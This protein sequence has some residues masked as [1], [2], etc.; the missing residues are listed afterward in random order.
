MYSCFSDVVVIDGDLVDGVVSKLKDAVQP[1]R[2]I[3][4]KYGIFYVTGNVYKN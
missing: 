1:L 3:K 2:D 4:S